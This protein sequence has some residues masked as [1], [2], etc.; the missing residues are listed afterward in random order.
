M[1]RS[2]SSRKKGKCLGWALSPR[3]VT[4][5]PSRLRGRSRRCRCA[6]RHRGP[7]AQFAVH[8]HG[9]AHQPSG[10]DSQFAAGAA[11]AAGHVGWCLSGRRSGERADAARRG[12]GLP[13]VVDAPP[14]RWRTDRTL[15]KAIGEDLLPRFVSKRDFAVRRTEFECVWALNVDSELAPKLEQGAG[16]W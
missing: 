13:S 2:L 5:A 15:S 16:H 6:H 1:M 7:A 10:A 14:A 4:R 9:L 3:S 12:K 11:G 8:A